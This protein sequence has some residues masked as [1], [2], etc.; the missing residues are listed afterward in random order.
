MELPV[1][2]TWRFL[3][4]GG[5]LHTHRCQQLAQCPARRLSSVRC[6]FSSVCLCINFSQGIGA[7]QG[8]L[9]KDGSPIACVLC[10]RLPFTLFTE[11]SSPN[12]GQSDDDQ[13][14]PL[15]QQAS[16]LTAVPYSYFNKDSM[17]DAHEID[18]L[19]LDSVESN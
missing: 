2:R 3:A 10:L 9:Q 19:F 6:V 1:R 11:S 13:K 7:L 8:E 18:H 5:P 4:H 16:L 14:P 15:H 17:M 12:G